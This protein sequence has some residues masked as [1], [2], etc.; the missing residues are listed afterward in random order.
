MINDT[1]GNPVL[2]LNF[3]MWAFKKG[4]LLGKSASS[5]VLERVLRSGV[6]ELVPNFAE[7]AWN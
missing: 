2:L 6:P 4:L 5:F 3:E 1:F 7:Q